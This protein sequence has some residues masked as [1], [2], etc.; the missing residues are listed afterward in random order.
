MSIGVFASNRQRPIDSLVSV[1]EGYSSV[2]IKRALRVSGPTPR[3]IFDPFGGS[4]TRAL[5]ASALGH[6]SAYTEVNPYM[7]WLA[8]VKVNQARAG[9]GHPAALGWTADHAFSYEAV[10]VAVPIESS[11]NVFAGGAAT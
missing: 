6:M 2:L 4:G 3:S 10:I 11:R 5:T 9:S 8:D 1:V 7:G